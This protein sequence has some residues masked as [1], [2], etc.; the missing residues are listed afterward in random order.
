LESDSDILITRPTATAIIRTTATTDRR[1]TSDGHF[2]G[3]TAIG[4]IIRA[5]T[6]G[7]TGTGINKAKAE[8]QVLHGRRR[9]KIPAGFYLLGEPPPDGADVDPAAADGS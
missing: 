2:T 9:T 3:I 7:I 6:I 5:A 1:S 4:F 8:T